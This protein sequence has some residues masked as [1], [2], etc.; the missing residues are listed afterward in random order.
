MAGFIKTF[1]IGITIAAIFLQGFS[2]FADT[3]GN[4]SCEASEN[5]CTCPADCGACS[6]D[7]PSQYGACKEF[8]CAGP[9]D[10][11]VCSVLTKTDCCG[12]NSCETGENYGTCST[13]CIPTSL[14][15]TFI[16]PTDGEILVKGEYVRIQVEVEA[17]G[18]EIA[19]AEVSATGFFGTLELFDDGKH[20]DE[21]AL[22]GIY[23]HSFTTP[24][25]MAELDYN[26]SASGSFKG[27]TG[28]QK[29]T[30][31]HSPTLDA[32]I[33]ELSP[34]TIGNIIDI[35]GTVFAKTVPRLMMLDV[36]IDYG[37]KQIYSGA[38]STN[39]NGEY[40]L[41]YH[42]SSFDP[43]GEWTITIEGRDE[44]NNSAHAKTTVEILPIKSSQG[45]KFGLLNDLNESYYRGEEVLIA[46]E[47]SDNDGQAITDAT[48]TLN[49][50]LNER[51][52][53]H[54][55]T[56]GKYSLL[57]DI[58]YSFPLE[59][60]TLTIRGN[61]ETDTQSLG[62]E[63]NFFIR[64]N[65]IEFT[66]QFVEK[67]RP[68][69]QIGE[70]IT[71]QT[72]LKYPNGDNVQDAQV[73]AYINNSQ[74]ELQNQGFGIFSGNYQVKE[75]DEGKLNISIEAKDNYQNT[76]LLK[77]NVNVGGTFIGYEL[78]K[79]SQLIAIILL[80]VIV[81]GAIIHFTFHTKIQKST[82]EK[83]KKQIETSIKELEDQYYS[84]GNMK[85]E[86]FSQLR[87]KYETELDAI[88][89]QLKEGK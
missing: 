8:A 87:E 3:C 42:T 80:A 12:N 32:T 47:L 2:A 64:V 67:L 71:L 53:L 62:G 15:L 59:V 36:N 49:T 88:Q 24:L 56:T 7:A 70:T 29:I 72:E 45:L 20:N 5:Q 73:I 9:D 76:T 28:K 1:L 48:V 22:D 33:N 55:F 40:L 57:Y 43:Y 63:F 50:P 52:P 65:P 78:A 39:A 11:Q 79:N 58:P 21:K 61:K 18:K 66:S 84:G 51:I 54:E 14:D 34:T 38:V 81:L 85:R 69:Y 41:P 86:E 82:A 30:I 60:S 44:N 17:D 23:G 19:G 10:S 4:D 13:D 35:S 74:V 16:S 31:T 77:Q 75:T 37:K 26:I 25:D 27:A 68:V 46:F 6:G 83:R 89:L